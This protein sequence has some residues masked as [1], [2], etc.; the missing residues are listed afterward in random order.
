[1]KE[2][3]IYVIGFTNN[4][5]FERFRACS[6]LW[7]ELKTTKKSRVQLKQVK[8]DDLGQKKTGGIHNLWGNTEMR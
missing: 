8:E 2:A 4:L 1:M 5:H 7:P 3:L 6:I